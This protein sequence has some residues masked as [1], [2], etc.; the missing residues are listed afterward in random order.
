MNKK[1]LI[2]ALF[3]AILSLTAFGVTSIK[4]QGNGNYPP[5]VQKLVERFGLNEDEV[6]QVFDEARG[7]RQAQMQANFEERLNQ[8]VTGGRITQEQ[9]ELILSKHEEMQANREMTEHQEEMKNWAQ[10]N[11]IDLSQIGFLGPRGGG[12]GGFGF[13]PRE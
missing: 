11:G 6:K 8:A 3:L 2:P 13:G 1:I 10:E 9:K 5:I 7:E 12:K 4:A